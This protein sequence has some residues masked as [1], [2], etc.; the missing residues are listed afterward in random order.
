MITRKTV[1][2]AENGVGIDEITLVDGASEV[3]FLTVGAVTRDWRVSHLGQE[4]P[5]VLGHENPET[6]LQNPYYFG[7]IAGRVANRVAGGRFE[8]QG[9]AFQC[10]QNEGQNMLHGGHVGLAK[11]L[12]TAEIDTVQNRVLFAYH[13]PDGEEGFPAAVDFTY[14]ISLQGSA[15]TYEMTGTPD[16]PTPINLAQ[17]SY[18]NLM[19]QGDIRGHHLT[20]DAAK[21]T[22]TDSENIPTGEVLPVTDT[23]YDFQAG[24]LI[25]SVDSAKQ[26]MDINLVLGDENPSVTLVAPNGLR[27]ELTTQEPGLQLYTGHYVNEMTGQ[28]G[29][30]I[31]PYSG[32]CL[33]AQHFPNAVNQMGFDQPI[34]TPDSPYFQKLV[35]D[36]HRKPI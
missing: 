32:V 26:G 7:A 5:V 30:K 35:V 31:G 3:K 6:Y 11:R 34:A 4:I 22:P 18:Y 14:A 21:Y 8:L 13:S 19:G 29:Q 12:F 27:L 16:R 10:S 36:I 17:H 2:R 25:S 20:V 15:L 24:G 33:E 1:A 28:N 23:R 9:K